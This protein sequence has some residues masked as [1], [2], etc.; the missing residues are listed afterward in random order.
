MNILT[1]I[2]ARMGSSRF[3]GKPL[4][5]ING[6]P[7]IH[8]I[9]ESCSDVS[10]LGHSYFSY[11]ATCDEIIH[12]YIQSLGLQSVMTSDKH[13]RCSDRC[14]EAL[15]IIEARLNIKFDLI[16]MVQGDEPLVDSSMIKASV[17]PFFLDD[18]IK[19][20][21]LVSPIRDESELISKNTIKVVFDQ[22]FNSLYFSRSPIPS[23]PLDPN[24]HYKQVC[25]IPFRR[26]YLKIYNELAPTNL[27]IAESVDMLRFL[28]H[29]IPVKLILIQKNTHPVD[30]PSDIIIVEQMIRVNNLP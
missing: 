6:K 19:V 21:N 1:L 17:E 24:L 8:H 9:A 18:N 26:E 27:E 10:F 12:N 20:V 4:A 14:C 7:M 25:V 22:Y 29:N 16:V 5:L 15:D 2:P 28:Q 11:V 13:Q 23:S 3:P 30:I